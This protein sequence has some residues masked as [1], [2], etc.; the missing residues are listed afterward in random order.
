MA[1]A[2]S[3]TCTITA[4]ATITDLANPFAVPVANGVAMAVQFDE[5]KG[6]FGM[7]RDAWVT[8]FGPTGASFSVGF[9]D[10]HGFLLMT[11][12]TVQGTVDAAGNVMLPSFPLG[13]ATDFC[14][15]RSPDYPIVADVASGTHFA[16]NSGQVHRLQGDP[17]DF[18]TGRLRLVGEGIIPAPCGAPGAILTGVDFTCT[19]A[20]IPDRTKLPPPPALAKVAGKLKIGPP[21]PATPPSK[22]DKGDTVSVRAQL[23]NWGPPLDLAGHDVYVRIGNAD[24]DLL[25]LRVPAGKF[26]NGAKAS[27]H[28]TDGTAIVVATGHKKTDAVSAAFGGS[29]LV[30]QQRGTASVKVG[31]V[32][33]DV[34]ALNGPATLTIAVGPRSAS[35][36][37]VVRGHGKHRT[38]RQ[39]K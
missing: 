36:N 4:L 12:G 3:G 18:T 19:L 37:V 27:V 16:A 33:L 6:T 35:A 25:V 10:V 14:P 24:T 26:V 1:H 34:G 22:P 2:T 21:L 39:T 8:Q 31:V 32:G 20:P 7:N 11:R 38:L 30:T 23:A 17:I 29:M 13:F 15:P 28:D 5:Q 9:G